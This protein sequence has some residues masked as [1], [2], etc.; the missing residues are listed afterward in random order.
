MYNFFGK[1]CLEL[2][3]SVFVSF[4]HFFVVVHNIFIEICNTYL[5]MIKYVNIQLCSNM[6]NKIP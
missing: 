4:P 3:W 1:S 6:Q 5:I 2:N